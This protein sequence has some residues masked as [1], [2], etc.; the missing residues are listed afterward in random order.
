[1]NDK[2]T[3]DKTNYAFTPRFISRLVQRGCV[4][5]ELRS[6]KEDM[7]EEMT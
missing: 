3:K 6:S 5:P 7:V 4:G 1:M 2:R